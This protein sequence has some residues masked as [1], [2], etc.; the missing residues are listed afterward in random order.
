LT[1]EKE[2]VRLVESPSLRKLEK[3]GL[4]RLINQ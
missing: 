3:G 2:A 1:R 4:Y